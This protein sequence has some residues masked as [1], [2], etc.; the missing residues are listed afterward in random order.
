M[1]KTFAP[2]SVAVATIFGVWISVKPRA[3]SVVRNAATARAVSRKRS[4]TGRMAKRDRRGVEPRRAATRAAPAGA[5]RPAAASAGSAS[6]RISGS[7]TSTP[8]GACSFATATPSISST[9]SGS[10]SARLLEDDLRQSGAVAQDEERHARQVA[11]AV[12]PALQ[13]HALSRVGSQLRS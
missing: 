9:V 2:P 11:P 5:A 1:R 7:C 13:Q 6:T 4:R 8:P 12:E 10:S 3:S